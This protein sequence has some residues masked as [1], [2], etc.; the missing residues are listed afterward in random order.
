MVETANGTPTGPVVG[1]LG[2]GIM[3]AAMASNLLKYGS[4]SKVVVWNRTL[5]KVTP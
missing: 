4:F 2:L 1:F 3:G 5:S